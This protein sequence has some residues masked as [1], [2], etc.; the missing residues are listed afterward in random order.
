MGNSLHTTITSSDHIPSNTMNFS[1]SDNNE[2]LNITLIKREKN[3]CYF[4]DFYD[5]DVVEHKRKYQNDWTELREYVGLNDIELTDN[6]LVIVNM[7]GLI[8]EHQAKT[9]LYM[10]NYNT[11][12]YNVLRIFSGMGGL[13][14]SN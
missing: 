6:E 10:S 14:Y 3:K 13:A 8:K 11:S 4:D 7:T 9:K 1:R 5:D 2:I 12:N